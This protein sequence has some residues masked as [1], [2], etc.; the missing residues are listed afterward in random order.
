[1]VTPAVRQDPVAQDIC[2]SAVIPTYNRAGLIGRAIRSVLEQSRPPQEI[3]VVDDGSTDETSAAVHQFGD[4]VRYVHQSNRGSAAARHHG[5]TEATYEWVALLDSDDVWTP[6]HLA[7]M[8]AAI[9]ATAGKAR[10]YFADTL[11][12]SEGQGKRHWEIAQFQI[13]EPYKLIPDAAAWVMNGRQPM[14]LQSTVFHRAAYLESGGFWSPLRYR[15]DTHLY[16]KLGIGGAACAVNEIGCQMTDDD[17]ENRLS[18]NYDKAKRGCEMQVLM[19]GELLARPLPLQPRHRQ[20]LQERLATA[21][22]CVARHAW[23]ERQY[24]KALRHLGQSVMVQP[25]SLGT[26]LEKV[27]GRIRGGR[28]QTGSVGLM[29]GRGAST[30]HSGSP[31]GAERRNE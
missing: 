16:L 10:F 15:D 6:D 3:I 21:H 14:M 11:R 27:L 31:L 2:I 4:R 18:A 9:G 20:Q 28:G 25:G 23:R 30:L 5:I 19:N 17:Q 26:M 12:S 1:M 7:R 8:A 22:R 13:T 29:P 24:T